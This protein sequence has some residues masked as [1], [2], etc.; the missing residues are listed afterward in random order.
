MIQEDITI[1]Q[2][3]KKMQEMKSPYLIANNGT[4]S[5]WDMVL[6]LGSKNLSMK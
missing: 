6:I 3:C 5:P 4:I 1:S 2:A